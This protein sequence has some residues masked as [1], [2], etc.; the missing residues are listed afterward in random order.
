MSVDETKISVH[1]Q[2]VEKSAEET[3]HSIIETVKV[4][5]SRVC[6]SNERVHLNI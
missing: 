4:K 5:V 2:E 6:T 3:Q 1:K